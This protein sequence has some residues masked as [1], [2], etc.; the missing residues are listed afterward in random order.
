[1]RT[2]QE[3]YDISAYIV[4]GFIQLR[5]YLHFIKFLIRLSCYQNDWVPDPIF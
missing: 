5:I 1:M 3:P 2:C 4:V